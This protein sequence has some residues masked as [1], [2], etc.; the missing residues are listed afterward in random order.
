MKA[1]GDSV[2]PTRTEAILSTVLDDTRVSGIINIDGRS[3]ERRATRMSKDED[4]S[5]G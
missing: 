4:V 1:S 2:M 3:A 5:K